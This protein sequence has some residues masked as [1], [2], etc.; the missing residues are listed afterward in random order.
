MEGVDESLQLMRGARRLHFAGDFEKQFRDDYFSNSLALC[1]A[2]LIAVCAIWLAFGLLDPYV[3]PSRTQTIWFIRYA[4]VSP[5]IVG[6]V[7]L[8][9]LPV[10]RAIMQPVVGL[11]VLVVGIGIVAMIAASP[12]RDP[13]YYL[14]PMGLLLT[15]GIAYSFLRLRFWGAT[16]PNLL[17]LLG[18]ASYAIIGQ[19]VLVLPQ[20]LPLFI[21]NLFFFVA[22]NVAGMATCYSL[23]LYA[24]RAFVSAF[25][26][27][28]KRVD[29]QRKRERTEAMLQILSQSTGG[30]V[31]DLGN[32]LT[33]VQLGAE[34]LEMFLRSGDAD[35]ET[36]LEFTNIIL[37]GAEMLNYLRL[38]LMEQ[39]RVLEGKPIPVELQPTPIRRVVEAGLH[40]QKPRFAAGR[41]TPIEG[42]DV[43]VPLDE[44]KMVTVLMNLIGNA[45]K[46][47]DGEVR[48]SWRIADDTLLL[49]VADQGLKGRG[50]SHAQAEQLFVAFGRLDTHA[51]VEGTGL[52]LLS[53]RKIV[54]AHGGEVFIEGHAD[55]TPAAPP[56]STAQK[57]Y[58][59]ML[60]ES[61]TA[62]VVACPVDSPS[63]V[64]N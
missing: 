2:A 9:F 62:F 7:V 24:R 58:P 54:E 10:F 33:S 4:L 61:C 53:V 20:Q 50:I 14:Y 40:Y 34:T 23:E 8:S 44:K 48:V 31:H 28:Q 63:P 30:V 39:T 41:K 6:T 32:P 18:Y 26:L 46:Y 51:Q 42:E 47:S 37:E 29:E 57:V 59:L 52:G 60:R 43:E 49:A 64:A 5:V 22:M 36:L 16:I 15:P 11:M 21:N 17:L 1:R 38:S 55:G 27:D 3:I 35:P 45:L 25:L 12:S 13:G 19:H 56:F